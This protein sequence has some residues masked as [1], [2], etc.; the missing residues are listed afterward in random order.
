M[1]GLILGSTFRVSVTL[2][3]NI[4]FVPESS[5]NRLKVQDCHVCKMLRFKTTDEKQTEYKECYYFGNR[6]SAMCYTEDSVREQ[7]E[8]CTQYRKERRGGMRMKWAGKTLITAQG[9]EKV[10]EEKNTEEQVFW[11]IE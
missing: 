9:V 1:K 8:D 6:M 4:G 10:K 3:A 7:S 5:A 2:A 11:R